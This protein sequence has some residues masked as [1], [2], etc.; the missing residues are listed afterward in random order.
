MLT[1]RDIEHFRETIGQ[2][3]G[4]HPLADVH[5]HPFEVVGSRIPYHSNPRYAGV[6]S[7]CAVDYR[8]PRITVTADAERLSERCRTLISGELRA[9]CLLLDMRQRYQHTGP[10]VIGDHM[11]LSGVDRVLLLPVAGDGTAGDEQLP[12]MAA[13]FGDDPRFAFGYSVTNDVATPQIWA[14]VRQAVEGYGVVALKLHPAVT[15][16]DPGTTAGHDRIEA[17]LAA[18]C[19]HHL[20]FIVHGGRSP[21]A[22]GAEHR[23][24]GTL[25]RLQPIDWSLSGNPVVI[26]HAGLYG[27][28]EEGLRR[29][30]LARMTSL[31]DRHDNVYADISGIDLPLLD[32]A[33]KAIPTER[34]VFGSD[35][36]YFTQWQALAGLHHALHRHYAD[37]HERFVTIASANSRKILGDHR[38][39]EKPLTRQVIEGGRAS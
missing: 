29:D 20:S 31:L 4:V 7:S 11:D 36:L 30:A 26:A 22:R 23:D 12:E 21:V 14:A 6:Y 1:Q 3:K 9:R 8:P 18:C 2:L 19:D 27:C 37:A 28:E 24:N 13:M 16:I 38:R 10:R 33:L 39:K 32:K 35:S 25:H 34:L 5:V 15:G 17:M